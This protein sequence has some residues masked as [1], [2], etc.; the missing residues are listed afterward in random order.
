MDTPVITKNEVRL[1]RPQAKRLRHYFAMGDRAHT[2]QFDGVD[3]DLLGYKLIEATPYH[4][5]GNRISVTP[6]GLDVLHRH[7]QADIA[8]RSGHHTLGNRLAEHLRKQGR[9]TW[10]NVEFRNWLTEKTHPKSGV[11]IDYAHWECVRPDVFSIKPSLQLKYANPT[12]HEVKVSRADF[13]GDLAR[14]EKRE[15]YAKMSEVVYYVA[16]EG[17]ISPDEVPQ[18]FGLLVEMEEG[19]FTLAKRPKRRKVELQAHHYLN[20]IVKPGQ[21][22]EDYGL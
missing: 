2:S 8:A 15:A 11:T 18:G 22:P 7:R 12:I 4:Y 9:I 20:M 14:P 6:F 13:L 1:N 3:L 21:Y 16:P 5:G 19:K 10:E 17:L